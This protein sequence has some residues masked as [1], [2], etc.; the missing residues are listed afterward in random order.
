MVVPAALSCCLSNPVACNRIAIAGGE[1]A[2]GDA[3]GPAGLGV[4]GTGSAIKA[5]RSAE[6]VNAGMKASG[7]EPAWSPGTPVIEATLQP[8]TKVNM[9]VDAKTAEAIKDKR[10]FVPGGWVTFDE[11]TSAA[12][13]MRQQSAIST[14][15][16]PDAD[17]PFYVVEMEITQP[18]TSNVGF[19]SKQTEVNGA[20]LRGGGTQVQFR[21]NLTRL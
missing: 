4:V 1:I 18:V 16:K 15:C 13:D 21:C 11:I 5:V 8:G 9:I 10:P 17:G 7:W 2:A 19:V 6:E 12:V 14:K 20:V 3:L